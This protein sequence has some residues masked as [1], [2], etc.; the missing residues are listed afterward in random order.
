MMVFVTGTN[1]L[2]SPRQPGASK[3]LN[4]DAA[5]REVDIFDTGWIPDID[6]LL[7]LL[8]LPDSRNYRRYDVGQFDPTSAAH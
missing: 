2:S 5:P 8:L 3:P 4:G 7:L 1:S 6:A